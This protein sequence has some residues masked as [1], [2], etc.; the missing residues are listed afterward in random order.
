MV[1][2][3]YKKIMVILVLHAENANYPQTVLAFYFVNHEIQ[4]NPY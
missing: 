4:S 3:I 2:A 1:E